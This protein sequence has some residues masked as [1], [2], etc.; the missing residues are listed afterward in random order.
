MDPKFQKIHTTRADLYVKLGRHKEAIADYSETIKS[1]KK[2]AFIYYNRARSYTFLKD[3]ASAIEDY[4]RIII[5]HP[6]G[7]AAYF[8][9]GVVYVYAGRYK[10]AMMDFKKYASFVTE[11]YI[12]DKT[13][14]GI[15]GTLR[16]SPDNPDAKEILM[17]LNTFKI[18]QEV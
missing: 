8:N 3:Y 15:K 18:P 11:P 14:M 5:L 16:R 9:R 6:E 1:D 7:A 12:N 10:E 13:L 4:D 2:N 17:L